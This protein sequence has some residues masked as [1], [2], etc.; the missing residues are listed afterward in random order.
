[1][2][3]LMISNVTNK[4]ILF[5]LIYIEFSAVCFSCR[6]LKN[7]IMIKNALPAYLFVPINELVREIH[8]L[9]FKRCGF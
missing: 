2:D 3:F 6:A 1:M 8:S 9:S 4:T 7:G 5:N